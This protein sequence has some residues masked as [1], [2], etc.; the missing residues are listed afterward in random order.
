MAGE[1]LAPEA[2]LRELRRLRLDLLAGLGVL[3]VLLVLLFLLLRPPNP[4]STLGRTV[5]A[6]RQALLGP[7][8]LAAANALAG[9]RAGGA[10]GGDGS[11]AGNGSGAGRASAGDSRTNQS[12]AGPTGGGGGS[13]RQGRSGS[14]SGGGREGGAHNSAGRPPGERMGEDSPANVNDPATQPATAAPDD[15]SL[16]AQSIGTLDNLNDPTRAQAAT[17][18]GAAGLEAPDGRVGNATN[19]GAV[20]ESDIPLARNPN[21]DE[22]NLVTRGPLPPDLGTATNRA[23]ALA[24]AA[25]PTNVALLSDEFGNRL[26]QAGARSGDVQIS[27]MWNNVNDLDLHCV[28]P[29]GEEI[30]YGHRRSASGG[31]LD[32]DMNASPPLTVRPVENIYWPQTAAPNGT[33]RILVNHYRNH[34]GRDPTQF[35]VRVYVKGFTTNLAG[36]ITFRQPKR[37]VYQFTLGAPTRPPSR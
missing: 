5:Q 22:T 30:Y 29:S 16:P 11:P 21:V 9:D 18:A 24:N 31:V 13:G 15:P 6:A 14:S 25:L 17:R 4:A 3:F 23:A 34:R 26:R 2:S 27:L 20:T 36:A 12:G 32:V 19:R 37:L 1:P 10:G 8:T 28:D 7:R 35:T 33:Y